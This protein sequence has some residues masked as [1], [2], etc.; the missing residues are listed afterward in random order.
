[1]NMKDSCGIVDLLR[2]VVVG[3]GEAVVVGFDV[4]GLQAVNLAKG[5]RWR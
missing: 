4:V 1:M 5:R 3:S 2:E